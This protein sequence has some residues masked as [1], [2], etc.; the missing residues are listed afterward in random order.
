M[1]TFYY[2][3]PYSNLTFFNPC[4]HVLQSCSPCNS[5]PTHVS[6]RIDIE[7]YIIPNTWKD[8]EELPSMSGDRYF[9]KVFSPRLDNSQGTP[10]DH[11]HNNIKIDKYGL[12]NNTAL[13]GLLPS[14]S[15]SI[16]G[17]YRVEYWR[18]NKLLIT[19]SIHLGCKVDCGVIKPITK[20]EPSSQ[21]LK[22]EWWYISPTFR[23]CPNSSTKTITLTRK[24][25][26]SIPT[27]NNTDYFPSDVIPNILFIDSIEGI[28][29]EYQDDW[30]LVHEE[31]KGP[32]HP[33]IQERVVTAMG[34]QWKI[35]PRPGTTYTVKYKTPYTLRDIIYNPSFREQELIALNTYS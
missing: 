13:L 16:K 20:A 21:L 5:K 23:S 17:C 14:P 19:P 4:C 29:E 11:P 32:F 9:L 25:D 10:K 15:R 18:W 34:I 27:P 22:S 26:D 2:S 7:P 3:L 30:K 35:G 24:D 1:Y 33:Q 31:I 6:V 28:P 8:P 12:F